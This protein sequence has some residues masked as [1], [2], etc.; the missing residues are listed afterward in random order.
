MWIHIRNTCKYNSIR[1]STFHKKLPDDDPAGSKHVAN[2][3]N[4]TNDNTISLA[5][6]YEFV[7]LMV[8]S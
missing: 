4:E 7:V 8:V 6:Y 3:H 2:V 1:N 5:I